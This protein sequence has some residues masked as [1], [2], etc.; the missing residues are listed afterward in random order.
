[1]YPILNVLITNTFLEKY[2]LKTSRA[3]NTFLEKYF[4]KKSIAKNTFKKKV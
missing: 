4:L 3:K 1:M 2:F